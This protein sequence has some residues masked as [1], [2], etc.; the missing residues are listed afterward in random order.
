MYE[1]I[2]DGDQTTVAE[3]VVADDPDTARDGELDEMATGQ[4]SALF[5]LFDTVGNPVTELIEVETTELQGL[6]IQG[7]GDPV[8]IDIERLI[9]FFFEGLFIR[10]FKR[11]GFS[12]ILNL[13]DG[14]ETDRIKGEGMNEHGHIVDV[15]GMEEDARGVVVVVDDEFLDFVEHVAGVAEVFKALT[16]GV[17]DGIGE[18]EGSDVSVEEVIGQLRDGMDVAIPGHVVVNDHQFVVHPFVDGVAQRRIFVMSVKESL[19]AD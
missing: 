12:G 2:A 10:I 13:H 4:K 16:R 7:I 3:E 1:L 8:S 17:V 14:L 5:D 18:G 19:C 15:G 6:A 11:L 9:F